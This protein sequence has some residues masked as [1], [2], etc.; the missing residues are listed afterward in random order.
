MSNPVFD[1]TPGVA[2]VS[3]VGY[4][5]GVGPWMTLNPVTLVI[6]PVVPLPPGNFTAVGLLA[7]PGFAGQSWNIF[8]VD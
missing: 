8:E 2:P 1:P 6:G 7:A 5:I 3:T 4:N